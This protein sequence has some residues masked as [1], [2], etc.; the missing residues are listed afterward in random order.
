M[1]ALQLSFYQIKL[2]NPYM[3]DSI[4]LCYFKLWIF[5]PTEFN[6]WNVKGQQHWVAKILGL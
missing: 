2:S 3:D 6:V 5:D 4:N 1:F